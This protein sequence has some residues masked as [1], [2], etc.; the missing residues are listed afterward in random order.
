MI[1]GALALLL[2][3]PAG[4]YELGSGVT[5]VQKVIQ[6]LQDMAAKG[7]QEKHE[8]Q[9]KFSAYTQF[10]DDTTAA[11]SQSIKDAN[12]AIEQLQADIQKAESDAS[13]LGK[14]IAGLEA[15][16]GQ[17]EADKAALTQQ[18]NTEHQDY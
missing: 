5:P 11:K 2:V 14:E 3:A 12:A 7:K 9:V 4:A 8:E 15:E 1:P 18:R 10:C 17:W 13:V 16:I 6:L